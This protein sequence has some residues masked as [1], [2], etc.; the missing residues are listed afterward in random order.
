MISVKIA[1]M[2]N[3]VRYVNLVTNLTSM[4]LSPIKIHAFVSNTYTHTHTH[5]YQH[6][7]SSQVMHSVFDQV[8]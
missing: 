3:S 4:F 1:Q 8:V 6:T 7:A 2:V 5:M